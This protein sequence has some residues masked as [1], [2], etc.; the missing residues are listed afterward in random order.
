MPITN[1]GHAEA[2]PEPELLLFLFPLRVDGE[3]V[4]AYTLEIATLLEKAPTSPVAPKLCAFAVN[5]DAKLPL[6]VV[7][8]INWALKLE[9]V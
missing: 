5:V 3:G 2:A 1:G 8:E 6:G 4:G 9:Y 7:A